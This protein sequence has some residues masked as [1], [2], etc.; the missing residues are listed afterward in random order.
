MKKGI[1]TT[2][3]V[4]AAMLALTGCGPNKIK[5]GT[6]L[7]KDK[8][9]EKAET[10]FKESI[11]KDKNIAEAYRGMGIARWEMKDYEG[12][13]EAFLK[14]LDNGADSTA[15]ICHFIGSCEM[16]MKH[17][18]KALNYYRLGMEEKNCTEELK[19]EMKRNEIAA[20][21]MLGDFKSA[22]QR[23]SKYKKDYPKD[24]K[25]KKEIEFYI[26]Q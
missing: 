6:Q 11:K 4:T 9:Y 18:Q 19:Q 10:A 17:P 2:M 5:E 13:E 26:T 25:M 7:L 21:E 14:A 12:A 3:I 1:Q 15:Q 22:K 8:E 24:K 23:L 16:K 20:Y